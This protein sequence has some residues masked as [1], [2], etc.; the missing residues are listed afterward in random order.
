V[1]GHTDDDQATVSVGEADEIIGQLRV[2]V[3]GLLEVSVRVLPARDPSAQFAG[4][5]QLSLL[6]RALPV[7]HRG[8]LR[9]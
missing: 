3:D 2:A 4:V 5:I 7:L 8:Q 1:V 9:R 6:L